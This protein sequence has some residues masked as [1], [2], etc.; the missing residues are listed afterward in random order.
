MKFHLQ[1]YDAKKNQILEAT[2]K[3]VHEQGA[4][5]V[6]MRSIAGRAKVSQALLHYYFKN[7]EN[8]FAEFIQILLDRLVKNLEK[9]MDPSHS[10]K[11]KLDVYLQY[12]QD[13]AEK[14]GDMLLVVQE[15]WSIS[16]RDAKLKKV[17]GDHIKKMSRVLEAILE[18]GEK[19]GTFK[20]VGKD[21]NTLNLGYFA[22]VVGM[23][24]LLQVNCP[25]DS[26]A[27]S[28]MQKNF[29]EMILKDSPR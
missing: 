4:A 1:K 7:K 23:G 26:K 9:G 21:L 15:M 19:E 3:C 20:K 5:A 13:Y 10:A 18:Q 25:P 6:T 22:F 11:K 12:G 27:F 17:L 2:F 24:I 28:I 8:L 14:H 29:K 16:I